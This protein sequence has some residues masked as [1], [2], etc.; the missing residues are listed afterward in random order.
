MAKIKPPS[1]GKQMERVHCKPEAQMEIDHFSVEVPPMPPKRTHKTLVKRFA[2]G[3]IDGWL[4][5]LRISGDTIYQLAKSKKEIMLAKRLPDKVALINTSPID[6]SELENF[7]SYREQVEKALRGAGYL[8]IELNLRELIAGFEEAG[9]Y[10]D[11]LIE[12]ARREQENARRHITTVEILE[13]ITGKDL[14]V[15]VYGDKV[16]AEQFV[17]DQSAYF[18][19]RLLRLHKFIRSQEQARDKRTL[20]ELAGMPDRLR[21][22]VTLSETASPPSAATGVV[23]GRIREALELKERVG[24]ILNSADNYIDILKTMAGG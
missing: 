1:P 17:R 11:I 5:P 16:R 14:G 24:V 15:R 20:E 3:D 9:G 7:G 12:A 2:A 6:R 23:F 4:N 19:D 10:R 21:F 18:D 13:E 22:A 8:T